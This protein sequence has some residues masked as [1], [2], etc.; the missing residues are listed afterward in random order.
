MVNIYVSLI[1]QG[2]RTLED[3]KEEIRAEVEALLNGDK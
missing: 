1:N 3:V 2:L